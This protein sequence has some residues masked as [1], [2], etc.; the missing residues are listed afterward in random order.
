VR[1]TK[2]APALVSALALILTASFANEARTA[3]ASERS[4]RIAQ[5]ETR[6][7]FNIPKQSLADALAAWSKQSGLQILRR[8]TD[9]ADLI[10]N[11]VSGKFSP[12]EALAK[13]LAAT[14]LTYEFVNDRTV[15]VVPAASAAPTSSYSRGD[16]A[17]KSL[18]A[19]QNT[20]PEKSGAARNEGEPSEPKKGAAHKSEL[21]NSSD[22]PLQEIQV[23][24]SRIRTILGEQ[25]FTPMVTFSRADIERAGVTSIGEISR[26]IPQAYS[27]GAYDGIG[28]GGQNGGMFNSIDGHTGQAAN[29]ARST[30]NLRGLGAQNTLVLV[31]G[32]RIAKSGTI[33]GN[34]A[35]DLAGIPISSIERI[36]VLTDGASAIYGSDAVGGVINIIQRKNYDG[37]EVSASYENT[38]DTNTAVS[39]IGVAHSFVA[40]KLSASVDANYQHRNAFAARDR[41]FTATTDWTKLGGTNP[42]PDFFSGG[43]ALG[44]GIVESATGDNLPGRNSPYALIP[45][46]ATGAP[47]PA[48]DY[49][50]VAPSDLPSYTGDTATYLNLISPQTNRG[51]GLRLN[52]QLGESTA[53]YL[54]GRYSDTRTEIE[55]LPVDFSNDIFI[56]GSDP[57]NPFGVDVYLDKTFWEL[58]NLQGQKEAKTNSASVSTGIQ[59]MLGA[60]WQYEVGF[61]W[62]REVL[63]DTDAYDPLLREPN[64][65]GQFASD[66]LVLLYDSRAAAPN[67]ENLLL[68]FLAPGNRLDRNVSMGFSASADGPLFNLPAGAL[69][70]AIGAEHRRDSAKTAQSLPENPRI[71]LNLLGNFDRD[72]D[73][74]YAEV[75]APII[76]AAQDIP[77]VYRIELTAA[78]RYDRYSDAGSEYSPRYGLTYR[79]VSW[80][81]LR[82]TRNYAFR[83]PTLNSLY[84]PTTTGNLFFSFLDPADQPIDHARND[85]VV[86][87]N[88]TSLKGGNL[89]LKP[90]TSVSNNIGIVLESPFEMLDGL[91]LSA[92]LI[93]I[94]YTNRIFEGLDAQYII[95]FL[96]ERVTRG[97]GLPGDPPGLPGRITRL[98][99]RGFNIGRVKVRSIDYQVRYTRATSIGTFDFRGAA[100]SYDAYQSRNTPVSPVVSSSYNYPDRYTWQAY[101]N[102]GPIGLGLSGFYQAHQFV[103][104]TR[105]VQRWGSAME[106]NGQFAYDFRA[107]GF[108]A[109]SGSPLAR[110]LADTKVALTINNLLDREPPHLQG[111][112]GFAVTDPR[113]RRYALSLVK[114]F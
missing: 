88:I 26:L 43:F 42:L 39:T 56:P 30:F 8:D 33:S 47:R 113:M 6:I 94:E 89:A 53:L 50:S 80:L 46:G 86:N 109:R 15:R 72:I 87:F 100:T 101:W 73:A 37:T 62:T 85:E 69:R 44:A 13:L 107:A 18:A 84:R 28:F 27:Q 112:A 114:T 81:M 110:L 16:Q 25:S 36:E 78:V 79:P 55:G 60:D 32:R 111:T 64:A 14:G 29:V 106:W 20:G 71:N 19:V 21:A 11:S 24:G 52:Y 23:T 96:P 38:F 59:G 2:S 76:S 102:R 10:A 105:T 68:S 41:Y 99:V 98:D 92:D 3:P 58:P 40:G 103:D 75:L 51:A 90:E 31:N 70:K 65:D 104:A 66:A 22:A 63:R 17:N 4:V 45:T 49:V 5:G 54:D 34:E 91:S 1:T 35:N 67:D 9:G 82:G 48:S 74:A 7:E 61:D 77:L 93:D 97:A 57:A 83:A 108:N 95:D 12:T